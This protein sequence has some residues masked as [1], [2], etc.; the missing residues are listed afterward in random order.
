MMDTASGSLR[1]C[2]AFFN[3]NLEFNH[4]QWQLELEGSNLNLKTIP[5]TQSVDSEYKKIQVRSSN[6]VVCVIF[7]SLSRDGY[8][9]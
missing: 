2:C 3:L 6:L 1:S 7:R 4:C 9:I 5:N 8:V